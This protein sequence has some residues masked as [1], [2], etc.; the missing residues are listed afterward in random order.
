MSSRLPT[1]FTS[2]YRLFLRTTSESVLHHTS[3]TKSLRKQFRPLFDSASSVIHTLRNNERL[4]TEERERLQAWLGVFD[5]RGT[6]VNYYRN[7]TVI[8][9]C[10]LSR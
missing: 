6:C 5:E 1:S 7:T 3:A 2:L 4:S 9:A 10:T 8:E